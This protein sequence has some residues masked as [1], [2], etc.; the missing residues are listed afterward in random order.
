M[1]TAEIR[2]LLAELAS[3]AISTDHVLDRLINGP[4]EAAGLDDRAPA[5]WHPC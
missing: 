3:G 1:D 4:L 5:R 2:S